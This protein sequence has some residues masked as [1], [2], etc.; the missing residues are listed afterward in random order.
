MRG[1]LVRDCCLCACVC[2]WLVVVL[3][4]SSVGVVTDEVAPRLPG[5]PGPEVG[6]HFGDLA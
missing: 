1:L 5:Q 4:S 3:G 2:V 6:I